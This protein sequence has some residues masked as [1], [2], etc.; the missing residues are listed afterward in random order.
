MRR[1]GP[2]QAALDVGTV[3]RVPA[4]TYGA[5]VTHCKVVQVRCRVPIHSL[6]QRG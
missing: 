6:R 5:A 4:S 2:V 3:L 1:F